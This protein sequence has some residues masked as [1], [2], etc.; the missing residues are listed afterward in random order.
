MLIYLRINS[1][2]KFTF[3]QQ[4]VYEN[5]YL[6]KGGIN[7]PEIS[8]GRVSILKWL[9]EH[10]LKQSSLAVAYGIPKQ[11]VSAYLSGRKK[12]TAAKNFIIKVIN[13]YGIK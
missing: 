8:N 10:D 1:I 6:Q 5:A 4:N 12:N 7:M 11:D 9:N 13:D 3:C 2:L